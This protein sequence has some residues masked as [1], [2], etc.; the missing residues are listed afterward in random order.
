MTRMYRH[1]K[2]NRMMGQAGRVVAELFEL[3]IGD[4]TIL[5]TEVQQ[6]TTGPHTVQTARV[7]SDY[8]SAMT[9]NFAIAEHRKLFTATGYLGG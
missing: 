9:D 6:R 5:P 3:F 1:Y 8:I 4:P 7:I 2:V